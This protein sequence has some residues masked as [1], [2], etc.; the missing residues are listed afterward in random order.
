MDHADVARRRA[1]EREVRRRRHGLDGATAEV[2]GSDA[3]HDRVAGELRR[4]VNDRRT[5]VAERHGQH[6][7]GI[8][9]GLRGA[10]RGNLLE[11][12][13]RVGRRAIKHRDAGGGIRHE[14]VA[15][16]DA[17][18]HREAGR[19]GG[20]HHSGQGELAEAEEGLRGERGGERIGV[21]LVGR[22]GEQAHRRADVG[23][24]VALE[25]EVVVVGVAVVGQPQLAVGVEA[26]AG[27]AEVLGGQGEGAQHEGDGGAQGAG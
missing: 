17:E 14:D 10:G 25:D 18:V 23:G 11:E 22:A 19:I 8:G 7:R 2:A 26:D 24:V 27:D 12:F 6:V 5:G 3:A 15:A 20:P 13:G 4:Q 16:G 1:E 21:F 9:D